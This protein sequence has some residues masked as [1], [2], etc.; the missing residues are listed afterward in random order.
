MFYFLG[1]MLFTHTASVENMQ[2][3]EDVKYGIKLS[4]PSWIV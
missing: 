1:Q 3:C 2:F 4:T